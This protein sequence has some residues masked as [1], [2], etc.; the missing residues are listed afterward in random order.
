MI[1]VHA[2][3]KRFISENYTGGSRQNET[4]SIIVEIDGMPGSGKSTQAKMLEHSLLGMG[5]KALSVDKAGSHDPSSSSIAKYAIRYTTGFAKAVALYKDNYILIMQHTP[6]F[7]DYSLG[8]LIGS[9]TMSGSIIK[10]ILEQFIKPD[11]VFYLNV[12]QNVRIERMYKR[13][14]AIDVLH[15]KLAAKDDSDFMKKL[16]ERYGGRF[17]VLDGTKNAEEINKHMLAILGSMLR[18]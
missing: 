2:N 15:E 12:P 1:E 3:Q 17:V 14:S 8:V 13:D 18:V 5:L 10:V 7:F 4:H 11:L 6:L 9:N 16:N